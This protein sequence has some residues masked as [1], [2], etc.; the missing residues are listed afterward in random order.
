MKH[1]L[2]VNICLTSAT[3]T[4]EHDIIF[5][6]LRAWEANPL[7]RQH[8][9]YDRRGYGRGPLFATIQVSYSK[10]YNFVGTGVPGLLEDVPLAV[11]QRLWLQHKGAPANFGEM[12]GLASTR[13]IQVG[14][15]DLAAG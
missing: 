9:A 13:H 2:W 3:V 8:L 12:S 7:Q 4:S 6:Q 5:K 1:V 10:T 11:R 15:L 14:Q